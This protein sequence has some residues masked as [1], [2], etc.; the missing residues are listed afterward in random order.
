MKLL[1]CLCSLLCLAGLS[2]PASLS[3]ESILANPS[4]EIAGS[5]GNNFAGW[6]QFG[7]TGTTGQALHGSLAAGVGSQNNG[8]LNVS[9]YWQPLEGAPGQSW[10]LAGYVMNPSASPIQGSGFALVNLE[11][12]NQA[13]GLIGYDS[14]TVATAATPVDEYIP[15]QYISTPA[16]AETAFIHLLAGLLQTASDP[17]MEVYYD[18]VTCFSTSYPTLD[19]TQWFDFPGGRTLQFSDRLWRVKGPGWYGPGNN[20]FSDSEQSVWVDAQQRLHLSLRQVSGSWLSS[21]VTLDEALGYGDY[22]FTTLGPL[23]TLDPT[24]VLGLFLWQ[25]GPSGTAPGSWWNPYNEIDIEYS[26]WGNPA[27]EIG[28]FVAQPWDWTGN[29][30]RYNAVFGAGVLSSH[31]FRWLPDRVEF[32]T[33]FGGPEDESPNTLISSWTYTGP[34]VP[35]PEQPRVHINLWYFSTPAV[36]YQEA[37]IDQFTFIPISPPD[38]PQN[39]RLELNGNDLRISWDDDPAAQSWSVWSSDDPAVGYSLRATVAGNSCLLEDEALA[40]PRRFYR[41][42]A[43]D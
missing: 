8:S 1:I 13:G 4:F 25:Y 39:V 40:Y 20:Y 34:H 10:K 17:A 7:A 28:Q 22:V 19:D 6:N 2:F 5:G 24:S 9:G 21:E 11:W 35:R 33:W 38:A 37:V 30:F 32:R 15:F 14:F 43:H 16:P 31:A 12:R 27:S 36:P 3:A 26:R 29:I 23:E 18:Q 41:I 42:I